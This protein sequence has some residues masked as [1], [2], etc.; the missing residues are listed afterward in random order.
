M[1]ERLRCPQQDCD[2]SDIN[3][4]NGLSRIVVLGDDDDAT[5]SAKRR[6]KCSRD[7]FQG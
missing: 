7:M 4:A 3:A 1:N 5:Y 2:A 6:E